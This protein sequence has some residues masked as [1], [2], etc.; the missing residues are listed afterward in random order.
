M[1]GHVSVPRQEVFERKRHM[2]EVNALQCIARALRARH[3]PDSSASLYSVLADAK[4]PFE[5]RNALYGAVYV[6][7][8]PFYFRCCEDFSFSA[9]ISSMS[10]ASAANCCRNV[11]VH[12]FV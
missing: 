8:C 11:T 7:T 6:H 2:G 12:G 9:Q 4:N 5:A 1:D 10:S 3:A